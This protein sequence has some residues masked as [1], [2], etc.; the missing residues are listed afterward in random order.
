MQSYGSEGL[1][2]MEHAET[3]LSGQTVLQL[4]FDPGVFGHTPVTVRCPLDHPFYIK[5]KGA[6][7]AAVKILSLP[8]P[9]VNP[10]SFC[11]GGPLSTRA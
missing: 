7:G 9:P 6:V 3:V 1:Q 5:S 4:T 11:Q 10:S 2:L 8:F